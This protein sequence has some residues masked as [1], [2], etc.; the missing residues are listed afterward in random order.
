MGALDRYTLPSILLII[1]GVGII[2]SGFLAYPYL[3]QAQYQHAIEPIRASDVSPDATVFGFS[4][5]S[6]EAQR[7]V[8]GALDAEDGFDI[9]YGK[10]NK[11]PEFVY[12][13]KMWT[14]YV[15]D[16][17]GNSFELAT[18]GPPVGL[19]PGFAVS[20]LG[21]LAAI[22]TGGQAL[23]RTRPRL[24]V[25]A[26][27][28]IATLTATFWLDPYNFSSSEYVVFVSLIV[29]VGPAAIAWYCYG[30]TDYWSPEDSSRSGE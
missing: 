3:G 17:N 14:L 5:L 12:Y 8:Q 19:P 6:P 15:I 13:E 30:Q 24:P 4:E 11:P 10:E 23:K 26:L 25:P 29:S 20:L 16:V 2:T 9:I 21:G 18:R 7:A 1:V 22:I 27:V 28:G